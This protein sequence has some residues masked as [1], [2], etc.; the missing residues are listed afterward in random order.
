[1]SQVENVYLKRLL[2]TTCL[3]M[4]PASAAL[5]Q[6]VTEGTSPAPGDFPDTFPGYVLPVGTT[7][8]SGIASGVEGVGDNDYFE[9]QGL[10]PGTAYD[11]KATF[12]PLGFE[13]GL[14]AFVYNSSGTQLATHSMEGPGA[15]FVLVAPADG[16]LDVRVEQTNS[17]E[18]GLPYIVNLTQVAPIV[19]APASSDWSLLLLIASLMAAS[20]GA[21]TA[22]A[23]RKNDSTAA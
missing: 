7:S 15:N 2:A 17:F 11:I 21:L 13:G 23:K 20:G 19:P 6:S 14:D 16:K 22:V 3:T 12:N 10:Q 5:A 1:M 18:S 9:F 4:L 8:V